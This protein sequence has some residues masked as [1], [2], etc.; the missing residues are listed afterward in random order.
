MAAAD[1]H[2]DGQGH[3]YIDGAGKDEGYDDADSTGKDEGYDDA[4]STGKDD[5][6]CYCYTDGAGKDDS[7]CYADGKGKGKD[8]GYRYCDTVGDG[9]EVGNRDRYTDGA[10]APYLNPK[11]V[12]YLHAVAYLDPCSATYGDRVIDRDIHPNAGVNKHPHGNADA[13]KHPHGNADANKYVHGHTSARC[14]AVKYCRAQPERHTD[15]TA[16]NRHAG[17]DGASIHHVIPV[18]H[19]DDDTD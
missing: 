12:A 10:V 2:D 4:D 3:R 7:H 1:D 13:D 14:D 16:A 15:D 19:G 11:A 18:H 17:P 8:G 6:P 5:G 9:V